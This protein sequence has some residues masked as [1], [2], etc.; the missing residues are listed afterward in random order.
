MEGQWLGVFGEESLRD[1]ETWSLEPWVPFSKAECWISGEA[2]GWSP[3]GFAE[4]QTGA[5]RVRQPALAMVAVAGP[6]PLEATAVV[7]FDGHPLRLEI[8]GRM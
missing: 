3:R 1:Q 2:A 8:A 5:G 7:T 6:V 4:I